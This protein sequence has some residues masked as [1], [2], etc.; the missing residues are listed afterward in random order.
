LAVLKNYENRTFRYPQAEP[1][2]VPTTG[3]HPSEP[4]KILDNGGDH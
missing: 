1:E 2:K 3:R 4:F